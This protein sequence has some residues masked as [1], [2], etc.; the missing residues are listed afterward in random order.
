LTNLTRHLSRHKLLLIALTCVLIAAAF[1][2]WRWHAAR[3][4]MIAPIAPYNF[5]ADHI[6]DIYV[7]D[8]WGGNSSAHSGGG[9]GIC[10]VLV[11][12]T[13]R[14]GLTVHVKWKIDDHWYEA[15]PELPP[16]KES[17]DLQ[18]VFLDKH[19]VKTYLLSYWPCTAMH[20]MPKQHLCDGPKS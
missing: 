20:P 16:Y 19:E 18:I 15:S 7:N 11:P 13:W 2:G 5:T 12:E 4:T 9:S 8:I 10:C 1:A 3:Q 14:P 17:A 6:S